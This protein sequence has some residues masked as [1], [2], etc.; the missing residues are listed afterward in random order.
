MS[1]DPDTRLTIEEIWEHEWFKKYWKPEPAKSGLYVGYSKIEVDS[2]ALQCLS[3]NGINPE[4]AWKQ[5]ESNKH[6]NITTAYYLQIKKMKKE[7]YPTRSNSPE[8]AVN[9]HRKTPL[10]PETK[11]EGNENESPD[12]R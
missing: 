2:E 10:S 7:L 11:I 5:I 1:T 8:L 9:L 4:V 6:S 3:E 12:D